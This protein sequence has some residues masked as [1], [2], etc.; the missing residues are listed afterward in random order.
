MSLLLATSFDAPE[1]ALWQTEL[2]RHLGPERWCVWHPDLGA[3]EREAVEIAIV[4]NPPPGSLQGL[5]RLRLI[6]SL[7]AGVDRLLRD[8]ALPTGV[9]LARMVDPAMNEAMAETA[10]WAVLSLQRG[11]F[12]YAE[13]QR[14]ARWL[15]HG[16]RRA[17]AFRVLVLGL[18]EMGRT[19]AG[20]LVRNGYR[21]AGWS[22]RP[23][24]LPGVA[25]YAGPEGLEQALAEAE[26]VVNLLP[27]TPA[28][29][30][31][32]NARTFTRMREGSSLVN[33]ARGSHVVEAD[34]LVALEEGR[35]H[36]AVLDVFAREPLPA[37]SLLWSHPRVTVL[38]HVAAQ[39]DP[40]TAARIAAANVRA[41]RAGQALSHL[42]DAARGY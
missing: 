10:L 19:V 33:L 1:L 7:W 15:R 28:T 14:E 29:E 11:Y 34:L 17:D 22:R 27:L 32:F 42:V 41:L 30:G 18:G 38:P 23:A 9:P 8:P 37:D 4:A 31:L 25:C 35:L 26:V 39:T 24:A 36:R 40:V 5:P 16:Q 21:V 12:D 20:R 3:A 2:E 6:Q 13:Q